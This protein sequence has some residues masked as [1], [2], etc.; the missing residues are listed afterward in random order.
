MIT[1]AFARRRA[2]GSSLFP[3]ADADAVLE[4]GVLREPYFEVWEEGPIPLGL[5]SGMRQ[6]SRAAPAGFAE[7]SSSP[8]P[9]TGGC[10]CTVTTPTSWSSRSPGARDWRIHAGPDGAGWRAGP[11]DAAGPEPA[12]I[13]RTTLDAGEVLWVP[14]GFAHCATGERGLS[15]HLPVTV[16]DVGTADLGAALGG[17]LAEGIPAERP[18]GD[19]AITGVAE[20]LLQDARDRPRGLSAADLVG[21]ARRRAVAR[22]PGRPEQAGLAQLA[23][24]WNASAGDTVHMAS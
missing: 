2:A 1:G 10:R 3:L 12:E 20:R 24:V 8:R 11:I 19:E 6:V 21:M 23:E 17:P 16:R 14:R 4:S 15:A 5:Y 13:L 7:S 18:L 9:A 22:M